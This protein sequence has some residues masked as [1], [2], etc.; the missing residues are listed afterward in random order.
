VSEWDA[1]PLAPDDEWGAFPV[2]PAAP[3]AQPGATPAPAPAGPS[4]NRFIAAAEGVANDLGGGL[5]GVNPI[6]L[7]EK[8]GQAV[9][10]LMDGYVDVDGTRE[11]LGNYPPDRFVTRQEGG[12]SYIYPKTEDV[13]ENPL[14]SLGRLFGYGAVE[15]FRG[16]LASR[17]ELATA[18]D[19]VG[20]TPSLAM[21]G[22]AQ[23]KVAAAG[24]AFGPTAGRFAGDSARVTDEIGAAAT[25]LADRAGPGINPADAGEALQR[26]AKVFKEGVQTRTRALYGEVDKL[27]PPQTTVQ[28]PAPDA[29]IKSKIDPLKDLPEIGKVV[30]NGKMEGMLKDLEGGKLTWTA[31]RQ[32]R[33]EIGEAIGDFS[34]PMSD[35]AK[36]KL[37]GIY[38]ALTKDLDAAASAGGPQAVKAWNRATSYTRASHQR[39]EQ[40]FTKIL[41][42]DSPE[43]AYSALTQMATEGTSSANVQA[44]HKVLRSL[45][46]EEASI[47]AGTVIRRLGRATAGAQDAAGEAFSPA[48]FLTNWNKMSPE[49]R[50]LI[51]RSGMDKGVASELNQLAKVVHAAKQAGTFRNHSNTGNAVVTFLLGGAA[52]A[53]MTT[54]GLATGGAYLSARAL[55]NVGFL[56]ALN[57]AAIAGD[58]APM[59]LIARGKGPLALE[60]AT[61][62]RL[63]QSEP[64]SPPPSL[65]APAQVPAR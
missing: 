65:P 4:P 30:G 13:K 38:A 18:A 21:R 47:V 39:I 5:Q 61:V 17:S 7:S 36:G 56:K 60:A 26:G 54:T 49:A 48:T 46:E 28:A 25:R 15:G 19:A 31:A 41:K 3:T 6:A 24:E 55:T 1:F 12:A 33:T 53:D 45:P 42:A 51:A 23:A 50:S 58:T 2:A 40:A 62:L 14:A 34:G 29:F 35:V 11:P 8:R 22:P 16:P 9:G 10:R 27:I 52:L 63:G 59:A 37:D 44:L 57:R 43:R 64:T 32:L 20:V